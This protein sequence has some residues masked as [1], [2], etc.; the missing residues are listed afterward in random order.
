MLVDTAGTAFGWVSVEAFAAA[1]F[2]LGSGMGSGSDGKFMLR[3]M[4]LRSS[5]SMF[6]L[7]KAW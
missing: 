5:T 6:S 2:V 3:Y 7:A 4:L 1:P